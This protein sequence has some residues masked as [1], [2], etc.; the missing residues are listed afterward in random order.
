M[1]KHIRYEPCPKCRWGGR[2]R[3]GDNLARYSDGSGHCF[4]CGHHE[5]PSLVDKFR[6]EEPHGDANKTVLPTDFSREVPA[7]AWEWLLQYGLSYTYW[8]P[9]TGYSERDER[10]ILTVGSPIQFSIGRYLGGK[11][12]NEAPR[13]WWVYGDRH[14]FADI[15]QPEKGDSSQAVVLVEDIISWHKV[16]QVA[17]SLCLFGVKIGTEVIRKLASLKRP[18]TLWLDRDQLPLLAP[19]INRLQALVGA[20]VGYVSTQKDPKAYSLGEIKEILNDRV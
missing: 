3:R 5:W 8:K 12:G 19:K 6:I 7:R 9:Y 4:S 18:V 20:S 13:K 2:D 17:P 1:A 15:L 10:L 11:T 16:G 14:G